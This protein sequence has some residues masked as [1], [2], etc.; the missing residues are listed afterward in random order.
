MIVS[1]DQSGPVV[2]ER[3][4]STR[5]L[6][7]D[8]S[9][10]LAATTTA[11]ADGGRLD[12]KVER[13]DGRH[14]EAS[15]RGTFA[16]SAVRGRAAVLSLAN[17]PT[18]RRSVTFDERHLA[19]IVC[20]YRKEQGRLLQRRQGQF[21]AVSLPEGW[22]V[23]GETENGID[24]AS[25]TREAGVSFAYA[26][27]LPAQ[28]TP[29]GHRDFTLRSLPSLQDVEHYRPRRTTH[30]PASRLSRCARLPPIG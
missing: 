26:T 25:P 19:E 24:V 27:N 12:F 28:T 17:A 13:V 23:T 15:L 9:R 29:E 5:E 21:F 18:G 8:Y 6:F 3:G 1:S 14:V 30:R 20:C 7:R 16:G 2:P 4:T 10:V 11:T 22:S